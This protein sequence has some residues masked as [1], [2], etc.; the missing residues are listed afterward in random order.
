M[1]RSSPIT[2]TAKFI[3]LSLMGKALA[4]H[5]YFLE[6]IDNEQISTDQ[7]CCE[8]CELMLSLNRKDNIL[9]SSTMHLTTKS[10]IFL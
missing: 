6:H 10:I 4:L 7:N 9:S 3:E 1:M 2:F 8:T 5:C